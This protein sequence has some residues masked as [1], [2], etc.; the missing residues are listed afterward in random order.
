MTNTKKPIAQW[1]FHD[2]AAALGTVLA[3]TL[4]CT[5]VVRWLDPRNLMLV[6]LL[7]VAFCAMRFPTLAAVYSCILSVLVFDYIFVPPAFELVPTDK[8][9]V[10]TLAVM[11]LVGL[12]ICSLAARA[13]RATQEAKDGEQRAQAIAQF[14][15]AVASA[16]TLAAMPEIIATRFRELLGWNAIYALVSTSGEIASPV[17]T[18]EQRDNA[19]QA[20]S[21]KSTITT[22]S[23]SAFIPVLS[24]SHPIGVLVVLPTDKREW[25]ARNRELC[26]TFAEQIRLASERM[27][28]VETA[29]KSKMQVEGM[30][31]R[32]ALLSSVS[33]DLR[34]PLTTI[35]GAATS[36]LS[37]GSEELREENRELLQSI[38][39]E[40]ERLANFLQNLLDMTRLE[41]GAVLLKKDWHSIE[42]SIG[43]ALGRLKRKVAGFQIVT[44]VADDMPLVLYDEQLVDQVITNLVDNAAKYAPAGT[45]IKL[46]AR[47]QDRSLLFGV[48]NLG[49]KL[50]PG[51]EAQ[52][53]EKFYRGDGVGTTYGAGL[54]LTICRGIML[55][56]GGTISA[57]RFG[58]DGITILCNLPMIGEP[59][60]IEVEE[61]A[62]EVS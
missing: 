18:E 55:A 39:L 9:Y 38:Q 56:H 31:I 33:H 12:L 51:A 41:S 58:T 16:R 52:I 7:G 28:S 15:R 37:D 5:L 35:M 17:L 34:T 32:N 27:I 44:D 19:N 53:F 29:E 2:F 21:E 62:E 1:S 48:S 6:Y 36:I 43:V 3:S 24:H 40:S 57:G 54:G 49:C 8:G 14:T 45:E 13:R 11:L 46:W 4:V 60:K 50:P 26:N 42:E 25:N 61:A 59:P 22:S 30:R 23:P 47:V 20:L 10:V